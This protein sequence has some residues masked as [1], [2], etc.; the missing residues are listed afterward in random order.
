M[1]EVELTAIIKNKADV[2][3]KLGQFA[4]APAHEVFYDDLYFDKKNEL[5][6]RESELRLRK[7]SYP[8]SGKITNWL[9]LKEAPFDQKTRS[10]PE[11]ETKITDFEAAKVIFEKLGYELVIRY[12]KHCRFYYARFKNLNLEI[13]VVQLPELSDTFIEI[14]AQTE[15]F[16]KTD[17]IFKILYTFLE[18]IGM[19]EN[20]LTTLQYQEMVME[21]RTK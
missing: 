7:K 4:T 1:Y 19:S 8:E 16:E 15:N 9:T 20:D 2:L 10:K 3:R 11:F 13:S 12:A 17:S 18:E 14:E 6:E 5:K 21:S